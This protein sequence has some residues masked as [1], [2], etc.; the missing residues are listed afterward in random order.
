MGEVTRKIVDGFDDMQLV[1]Q[2]DNDINLPPYHTLNLKLVEGLADKR[3][4]EHAIPTRGCKKSQ[5]LVAYLLN[6]HSSWRKM[7]LLIYSQSRC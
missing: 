5:H 6:L 4:K 7:L 2:T 3:K 1:L